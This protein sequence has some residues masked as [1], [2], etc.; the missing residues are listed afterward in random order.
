MAGTS[1]SW[2]APRAASMV[3]AATGTD[4][5]HDPIPPAGRCQP[6]DLCRGALAAEGL[7]HRL[8]TQGRKGAAPDGFQLLAGMSPCHEQHGALDAESL[9]FGS[10]PVCRPGTLDVAA[11]AGQ[12]RQGR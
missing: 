1:R 2:A 7:H 9:Q 10:E 6:L 12:H 8:E 11:G 5:G 3:F 4:D